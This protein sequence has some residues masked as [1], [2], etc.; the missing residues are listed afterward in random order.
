M[1]SAINHMNEDHKEAVIL[2]AKYFGKLETV[3]NA[4]LISINNNNIIITADNNN[5]TIETKE[6]ITKA[7]VKNILI[8]LLQEAKAHLKEESVSESSNNLIEEINSFIKNFKS[9]TLATVD[10]EGNPYA[11]YA[12]FI[13]YNGKNYIYISEIAEH[14]N[15]LIANPN[16]EVMFIEDEKT[17][18]LITARI[19]VRFK[20]T[21]KL[22]SRDIPEFNNIMNSLQEKLGNTIKTLRNMTDFNLFEITFNSG[23]YVKGF[24]KAFY[25]KSHNNTFI[26]SQ[27]T[28]KDLGSNS[29][30]PHNLK[31]PQS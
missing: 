3:K 9:V 22:L 18:K 5:I 23:R 26:A 28:G 2:I 27:I 1:Q 21:A 16:L 7:N 15:N 13:Q 29:K 17:A 4:T 8:S 19:R 24:G 20:S 31:L 12:P 11:T 14:Y 30:M 25:L 6:S 10:S